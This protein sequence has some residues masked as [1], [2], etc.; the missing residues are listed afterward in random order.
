MRNLFL[1]RVGY[2]VVGAVLLATYMY[3]VSGYAT[4]FAGTKIL[5]GNCDPSADPVKDDEKTNDY[6]K[7]CIGQGIDVD[8]Y[9][10]TLEY[11]LQIAG[12]D[13]QTF[14]VELGGSTKNQ[15][16][17]F[18]VELEGDKACAYADLGFAYTVPRDTDLEIGIPSDST[19]TASSTDT[20]TDDETQ[21]LSTNCLYAPE[22]RSTVAAPNWSNMISKVCTDY[23]TTAS[24]FKYADG[25][26]RSFTGVLIECIEESMM[27]IFYNKDEGGNTFF[28]AMQDNLRKIIMGL[29][30]LYVIFF[31]YKFVIE[32]KGIAQGE[33]HWFALKF[34]MVFYF[35]AGSGM[36]DLL[37]KIQDVSRNL[38]LI[39]M[40]SSFGN[41]GDLSAAQN[42]LIEAQEKYDLARDELAQARYSVS[43]AQSELAHNPTD[44]GLQSAVDAAK[45]DRDAKQI[46]ADSA[47]T[48]LNSLKSTALSFG[49]NYCDFRPYAL[50]GKYNYTLTD[51]NGVQ[52]TKDMSTMQLW[53]MIDCRLSKYLGVGDNST[54]TKTPHLLVIAIASIF[55]NIYGFPI[56]IC[57]VVFLAFLIIVTIRIVQA[58]IIAFVALVILVYMSPLIIP[59]VLFEKTKGIFDSWF[60][61]IIAFSLQP[62]ILFSFLVFLFAAYDSMMFGG[63]YKFVPMTDSHDIHENKL[64]MMSESSGNEVCKA[65]DF[66]LYAQSDLYCEDADAMGCVYERIVE[67]YYELGMG[68][69]VYMTNMTESDGKIMVIAFLKL[70]L[71]SILASA[72]LEFVESLSVRLVDGLGSAAGMTA[73]PKA[74]ASTIAKGVSSKTVEA[75]GGGISKGVG[76]IKKADDKKK[77][78]RANANVK[79]GETAKSAIDKSKADTAK[80]DL[81]SRQAKLAHDEMKNK[82]NA[83]D[84]SGS[85]DV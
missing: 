32:K 62:V 38:S 74:D 64:C 21:R 39:I 19:T 44:G 43:K 41:S 78:G 17:N 58:Y 66:A 27:N 79:A 15:G 80:K 2:F 63:N 28:S 6:E 59:A 47:L 7:S 76:A 65:S 83:S 40:E 45:A 67:S 36:I 20:S 23:D 52:T 10:L 84:N 75:V 70:I 22:P 54:D 42:N 4:D 53:D 33:W 8:S 48:V 57:A 72:V 49:Y 13:A 37:P 56:F 68:L 11:R 85:S 29:L 18:R 55:T 69:R 3:P 73:T 51:A 60:K 30:T 61:Q 50:A 14:D 5:H 46:A 16:L 81:V 71:V 12:V 35:A 34:A 25:T 1:K 24:Q 31:G 77:A 82:A 26:T 9:K